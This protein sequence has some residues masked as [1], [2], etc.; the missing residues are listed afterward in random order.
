[1]PDSPA[2]L[3]RTK[4]NGRDSS[5]DDV[6]ITP[7]YLAGSP[8]CG[9]DA[10]APLTHH[11]WHNMHDEMGN[12]YVTT[13]GGQLRVA[14]I[15]E[16][17]ELIP[18][19]TALWQIRA[20]NGHGEPSTWTAAFTDETPPEIIAGLT[21]ALDADVT[22]S[23]WGTDPYLTRDDHPDVVWNVMRE[24]G[25]Q[26][27]ADGLHVK[28]TSPDRLASLAYR[29][30]STF[31]GRGVVRD[32]A[33]RATVRA[34]PDARRT[35][36]EA[37]FHSATPAHLIAAFATALTNPDPLTRESATVPRSC[38]TYA[39]PLHA[40]TPPTPTPLD[41]RRAHAARPRSVSTAPSLLRWSTATRTPSAAA[42][43]AGTRHPVPP[44]LSTA[45]ASIS[46]R[47]S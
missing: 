12:F 47:T 2:P 17:S 3:P 34:T 29:P 38:R 27:T 41:V 16:V 7:R 42:S 25:W 36:W 30:P 15:P 35:L 18:D 20:R 10:F 19:A 4:R 40:P 44:P 5:W 43:T 26:V 23:G 31:G 22:H 37:D 6:Q 28:A 11:Y 24:A 45:S 33:W 21:A 13:M 39:R 46:R 14:F 8:G 1:M 32:E 9:D